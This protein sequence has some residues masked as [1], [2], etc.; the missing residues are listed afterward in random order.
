MVDAQHSKHKQVI[1]RKRPTHS[2]KFAVEV[3][4]EPPLA[5][6]LVENQYNKKNCRGD[7]R[8]TLSGLCVVLVLLGELNFCCFPSRTSSSLN[9]LVHCCQKKKCRCTRN[10]C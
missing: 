6:A 3:Q 5:C 10:L 8:W 4:T 1:R 7:S 2:Q 9:F